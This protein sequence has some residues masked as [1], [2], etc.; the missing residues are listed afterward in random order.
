[1]RGLLALLVPF[2]RPLALDIVPVGLLGEEFVARILE[3]MNCLRYPKK[4]PKYH[5]N[6]KSVFVPIDPIGGL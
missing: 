4:T 1:M 5:G 3:A 6:Q 2:K